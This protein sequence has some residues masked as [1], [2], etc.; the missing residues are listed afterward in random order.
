MS[1]E[2]FDRWVQAAIRWQDENPEVRET[3]RNL[4]VKI[5]DQSRQRVDFDASPALLQVRQAVHAM[6]VN[7]SAAGVLAGLG[8]ATAALARRT[9]PTGNQ[10]QCP[11]C[12]VVHDSVELFDRHDC[13][14]SI[15]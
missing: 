11:R 10:A 14:A 8:L 4:L 15:A 6:T 13:L 1:P 5:G 12:L 9:T 7:N 2:S 3:V